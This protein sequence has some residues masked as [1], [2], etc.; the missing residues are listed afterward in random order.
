MET[1]NKEKLLTRKELAAEL[2]HCRQF[3]Y[4]ME[5]HGF[6]MVDGKATVSQAREWLSG[7]PRPF[8]GVWKKPSAI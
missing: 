6:K 3:V 1:P 2:G 8:R 4:K 7:N 5:H